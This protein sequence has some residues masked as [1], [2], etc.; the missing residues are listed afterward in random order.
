MQ[1]LFFQLYLKKKKKNG[2]VAIND[3]TMHIITSKRLTV[4]DK[5]RKSKI[6]RQK[7]VEAKEEIV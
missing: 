7:D 3:F 5:N 2:E 1:V 4:Q 6:V